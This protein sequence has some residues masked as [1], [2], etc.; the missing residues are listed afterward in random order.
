[1]RIVHT[2][3]HD[4]DNDGR[5]AARK[6]PGIPYIHVLTDHGA[7]RIV[8][9]LVAEVPL[10]AEKRVV[11]SRAAGTCLGGHR[12][13]TRSDA[14]AYH[15]VHQCI[16]LHFSN[17]LFGGKPGS[18]LLYIRL[19]VQCQFIPPVQTEALFFRFPSGE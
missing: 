8:L 6:C 16:V 12:L 4:C 5:V 17:L 15:S 11:H 3:I 19:A 18:Y 1:M 2:L 10:L 7:G 9:G 13:R 14:P